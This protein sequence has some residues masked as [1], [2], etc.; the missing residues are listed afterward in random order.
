VQPTHRAVGTPAP[1]KTG[2]VG[3]LTGALGGHIVFTTAGGGATEVDVLNVANK[4]ISW[5]FSNARQPDIRADGRVGFDGTGGGKNNIFS[6]NLDGTGE[7]MNGTHPEDS[8][9]GWSPS[10]QSAV[11]YSTSAMVASESIFSG[12]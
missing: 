3:P 9:P 2:V 4:A 10:G 5:L 11:F 12:T 7:M 8:Y 1:T 6:I